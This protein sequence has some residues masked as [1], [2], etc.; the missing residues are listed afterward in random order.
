MK[1]ERM[2]AFGVLGNWRL[3][4]RSRK[5]AAMVTTFAS[6]IM[7]GCIYG[8]IAISKHTPET[9]V[10]QDSRHDMRACTK[11]L[12]VGGREKALSY[13]SCSEE[14][15]SCIW[16]QSCRPEWQA[17]YWCCPQRQRSCLWGFEEKR[18]KSSLNFSCWQETHEMVS[19]RGQTKQTGGLVF[20][21]SLKTTDNEELFEA[22]VNFRILFIVCLEF[23]PEKHYLCVKSAMQKLKIHTFL[24]LKR[25]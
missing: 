17:G 9:R 5:R 23:F 1:G 16:W 6:S 7:N 4:V 24:H 25:T 8:N 21:A 11:L 20:W 19:G 22:I 13:R 10:F 15:Q 12:A 14:L 3:L 2:F 18:L